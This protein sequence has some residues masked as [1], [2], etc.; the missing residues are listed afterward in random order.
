MTVCYV[1]QR[2]REKIAAA[3]PITLILAL[4]EVKKALKATTIIPLAPEGMDVA[5]QGGD[6]TPY[7]IGTI[8]VLIAVALPLGLI[9]A[10][11]DF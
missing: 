8:S 4:L 3:D 7:I 10:L 1:I 11:A 6:I 9:T 5:A 2:T